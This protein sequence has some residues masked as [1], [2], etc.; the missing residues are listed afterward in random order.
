LGGVKTGTKFVAP[1]SRLLIEMYDD[2]GTL[3]R[4]SIRTVPQVS[5]NANLLDVLAGR[6]VTP[7]AAESMDGVAGMMTMLQRMGGARSLAPIRDSIRDHV[8]RRPSVIAL[9]L[10]GLRLQVD[11]M[12]DANAIALTQHATH[13]S[14]AP[15][16]ESR[17]PLLLSGQRLFD[18]RVVVGQPQAPYSLTGGALLV[19]VAHPEKSSNRLTVCV[20]AAKSTG[21]AGAKTLATR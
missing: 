14:S 4:S 6:P 7:G 2:T 9:L 5:T 1:P 19:E 13:L 12:I 16:Y 15:R 11:A 21:R 8:V 3:L 10:A 18:C 20:L 17:F